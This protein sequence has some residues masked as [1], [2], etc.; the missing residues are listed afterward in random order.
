MEVVS[1]SLSAGFTVLS[2]M[3]PVFSSFSVV[4]CSWL[5]TIVQFIFTLNKPHYYTPY[6]GHKA[7]LIAILTWPNISHEKSREW[8]TIPRVTLGAEIG[9]SSQASDVPG[10]H[11][12]KHLVLSFINISVRANS[13]SGILLPW[14][15]DC[16]TAPTPECLGVPELLQ[17]SPQDVAL[18]QHFPL[19]LIIWLEPVLFLSCFI[20]MAIPRE[21]TSFCSLNTPSSLTEVEVFQFFF[22]LTTVPFHNMSWVIIISNPPRTCGS[23]DG[24]GSSNNPHVALVPTEYGIY[25]RPSL[26]SIPFLEE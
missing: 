11:T 6:S 20:G 24:S 19:A 16:P 9:I 2:L 15:H 13:V 26:W 17:Y 1:C 7:K 8:I 4:F 14:E 18:V 12:W 23:M 3:V 5:E 21:L 25:Q 10:N 22:T